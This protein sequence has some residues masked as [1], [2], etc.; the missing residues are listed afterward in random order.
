MP[1]DLVLEAS[2]GEAVALAPNLGAAGA[3]I[4]LPRN[5]INLALP[6][7]LVPDKAQCFI[8]LLDRHGRPPVVVVQQVRPPRQSKYARKSYTLLRLGVGRRVRRWVAGACRSKDI[9]MALDHT[10]EGP[11]NDVMDIVAPRAVLGINL[12]EELCRSARARGIPAVELQHGM[13]GPWF[14]QRMEARPATDRPSHMLTWDR[15][16]N[17]VV[18]PVG[19]VAVS[20]G[21]PAL[22]GLT[23]P[24]SPL[25]HV[26]IQAPRANAGHP[27]LLVTLQYRFPNAV[28]PLGMISSE[29]GQA[30]QAIRESGLLLGFRFRIHPTF[31]QEW[32]ATG[33]KRWLEAN[34]PNCEVSV[35]SNSYIL[36]DIMRS[37][38]VLTHHSSTVFEAAILGR[39]SIV[40]SNGITMNAQG[41]DIGLEPEDG[42]L[43]SNDQGVAVAGFH[44][45]IPRGIESAGLITVTRARSVPEVLR[46]QLNSAFLPYRPVIDATQEEALWNLGLLP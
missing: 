28:D 37:N 33:A 40:V 45:D 26:G 4:V 14:R 1:R 36:N 6:S 34:F 25:A 38:V 29:I 41:V 42:A 13:I 19:V 23:A 35:P 11:W 43:T 10:N 9:A 30:L 17:Q 22:P 18:E 2:R 20:T 39:P 3:L 5:C 12:D 44:Q 7:G 31:E 32:G 8:E 27:T 46:D 24:P 21:Y 16:Y 15:E